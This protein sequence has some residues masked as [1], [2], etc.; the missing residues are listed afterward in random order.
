M[1]RLDLRCFVKAA[2]AAQLAHNAIERSRHALRASDI[3]LLARG[4]PVKLERPALGAMWQQ[5][6][7]GK[8]HFYAVDAR[9]AA[10]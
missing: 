10:P 8:A 3:V 7:Q 9:F 2:S 6:T 5:T 4:I 1:S